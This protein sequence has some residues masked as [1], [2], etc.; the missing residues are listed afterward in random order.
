L[1]Q[2]NALLAE[3]NR[4]SRRIWKVVAITLNSIAAI[5]AL[6]LILNLATSIKYNDISNIIT[7]QKAQINEPAWLALLCFWPYI[8][9]SK[10]IPPISQV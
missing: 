3:K 7:E 2:L 4:R 6:L 9:R 10:A 1:E 8:S 5:I